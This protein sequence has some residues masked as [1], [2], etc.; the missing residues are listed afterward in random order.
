[1][2]IIGVT[3]VND[4]DDNDLGICGFLGYLES[5]SPCTLVGQ[6]IVE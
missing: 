6:V 2:K 5:N 1:M 3:L 4:D